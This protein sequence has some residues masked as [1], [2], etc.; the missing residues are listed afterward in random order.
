MAKTTVPTMKI[1]IE[2]KGEREKELFIATGWTM[3]HETVDPFVEIQTSK[4]IH[5]FHYDE[6]HKMT[7]DRAGLEK[8]QEFNRARERSRQNPP[9]II[10]PGPGLDLP[11]RRN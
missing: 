8:V 7:I 11:P 10:K 2:F 9:N 3:R 5:F 1:Q 4:M 6:I